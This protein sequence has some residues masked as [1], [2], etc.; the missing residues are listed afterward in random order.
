MQATAVTKR[1][2]GWAPVDFDS[3]PTVR[4]LASFPPHPNR[5]DRELSGQVAILNREATTR[6]SLQMQPG[7][8]FIIQVGDHWEVRSTFKLAR[9]T[10]PGRQQ[11]LACAI[12]E[13]EALWDEQHVA[14][15]VR[16]SDDDDRWHTV[17][18][19]G[20]LLDPM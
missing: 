1:V 10:H 11:A 7:S 13:A 9:T 3:A 16:I 14:C 20:G 5:L 12:A 19:F 18:T 6:P 4:A 8:F 15:M 2:T 17:R